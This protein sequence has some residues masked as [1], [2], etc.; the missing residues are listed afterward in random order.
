MKLRAETNRTQ[1]RSRKTP[2]DPRIPHNSPHFGWDRV[3]GP[4]LRLPRIVSSTIAGAP[5]R[6]ICIQLDE[7]VPKD[8][9]KIKKKKKNK[10]KKKI[11]QN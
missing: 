3:V 6:S 1:E 7:R 2:C 5:E 8:K 9:K 10:K 11:K 4:P